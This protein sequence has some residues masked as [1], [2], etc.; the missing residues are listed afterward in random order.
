MS[1][2]PECYGTIFPDF[3]QLTHRKPVE[4]TAF[5]AEVASH[6]LGPQS[7][8]S[9]VKR[10]GCATCAA[11]PAYR[12]CSDFCLAKLFMN[13]LLANGGYGA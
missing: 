7:R 10:E 8:R 5:S 11:C 3:A 12:T 6:R 1:G 4:A 9:R 13:T 2:F